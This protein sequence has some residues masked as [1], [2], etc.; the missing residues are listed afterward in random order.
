MNG[1]FIGNKDTVRGYFPHAPEGWYWG[2]DYTDPTLY[3][4]GPSY[5]ITVTRQ[6]GARWY[7]R[8]DE[9]EHTFHCNLLFKCV[10]IEPGDGGYENPDYKSGQWY[11][12]VRTPDAGVVL[13]HGL[14]DRKL[15]EPNDDFTGLRGGSVAIE[16][17]LVEPAR[18]DIGGD[19]FTALT[20]NIEHEDGT[21]LTLQPDV[22]TDPPL[23]STPGGALYFK[24]FHE[25]PVVETLSV[26]GSNVI[27]SMLFSGTLGNGVSRDDSPFNTFASVNLSTTLPTAAY[28]AAYI[29]LHPG[30]SFNSFSSNTWT[31]DGE[32]GTLHLWVFGEGLTAGIGGTMSLASEI[33]SYN[34]WPDADGNPTRDT[35]TGALL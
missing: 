18:V 20:G 13:R 23:G 4:V 3:P 12:R 1:L 8:V 2:A 35:T 17:N 30:V 28:I 11:F 32:E 15:P 33:V 27:P 26:S 14:T 25:N 6:K 31:I 19:L 29:A 21:V 9:M 24:M 16:Q 10:F 22:P 5:P 7:F 34:P